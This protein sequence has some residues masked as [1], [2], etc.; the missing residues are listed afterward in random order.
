MVLW[1]G[2]IGA[3]LATREEKHINIDLFG[4]ML[5]GK[6]KRVVK[7]ITHLFSAVVCLFLAKAAW[8]FVMEE[9]EMATT[10]FNEIPAWYF[11]MILPVG[12]LLM[13]LRFL[14]HMVDKIVNAN[15]EDVDKEE[16]INHEDYE[17]NN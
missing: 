8:V 9:R 10:L 3:S 2:F 17:E 12:F 14:I 5:P 6:G 16:V 11:Q 4:R 15:A 7:L 13:A 1:I